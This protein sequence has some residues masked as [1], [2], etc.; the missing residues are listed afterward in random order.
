MSTGLSI[1]AAAAAAAYGF[2]LARRG[3]LDWDDPSR[4]QT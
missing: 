3:G 1:Q 4:V 2:S